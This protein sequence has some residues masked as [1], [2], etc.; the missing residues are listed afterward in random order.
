[1]ISTAVA[2]TNFNVTFSTAAGHQ[3]SLEASA[4]LINWTPV[5]GS[6]FTGNGSPHT[7]PVD[8]T[9]HPNRYFVRVLVGP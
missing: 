3:Y 5:S 6:T 9:N 2:G 1:V 4:D 7:S 8:I